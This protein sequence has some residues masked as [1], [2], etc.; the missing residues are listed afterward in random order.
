MDCSLPGSS[1]P[2]DSP[3]K[4]TRVVAMPSSRRSSQPRD[5]T[6]VSHIAGRFFYWLSHQG[7]PR[8][9][10]WVAYHFSRGS[11]WPRNCTGVSWV[12]EKA[13]ATHCSTLAWTIPWTEEL[14][15]L[16]CMGSLTVG[17]N[18]MTS[19]SLFTFM[20]WRR[21]WQL[22]LTGEPGGLP[23]MGLHR[24]TQLKWLSSNS[25]SCIASGLFISWVTREYT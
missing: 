10:E 12:A 23:S 24:Q 20:H 1:V 19:L 4:N 16:Q 9:L 7:S 21:K 3:G 6:Q 13:M 18:W 2:G 22:T 15:R 17:H 25:S 5:W 8:I 11:S 14:G